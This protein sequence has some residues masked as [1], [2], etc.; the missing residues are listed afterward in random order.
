MI[1]L[2]IEKPPE[3]L[4]DYVNVPANDVCGEFV[5]SLVGLLRQDVFHIKTDGVPLDW[6]TD[7]V[8][9]AAKDYLIMIQRIPAHSDK[10]RTARAIFYFERQPS[11]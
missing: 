2:F 9:E 11:N 1:F 5:K 4:K 3:N 6:L 7:A 8:I 10:R